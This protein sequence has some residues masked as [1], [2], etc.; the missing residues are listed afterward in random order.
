M[1]TTTNCATTSN[2]SNISNKNKSNNTK[3]LTGKTVV[4]KV[5]KF[6][7]PGGN[8]DN[9][10]YIGTT[11]NGKFADEINDASIKS[12]AIQT[13]KFTD[14]KTMITNKAILPSNV[15]KFTIGQWL[16]D[17]SNKQ[18]LLTNISTYDTYGTLIKNFDYASNDSVKWLKFGN[19]SI[20]EM[21]YNYIC[22]NQ[23]KSLGY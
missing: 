4:P 14:R 10:R 16:M 3:N 7:L 21:Q 6:T 13:Y 11:A 19:G 17:C 9:W 2:I 8:L 18:Y 20:A 1:L 22:L 12:T 23:N 5:P 15:Y